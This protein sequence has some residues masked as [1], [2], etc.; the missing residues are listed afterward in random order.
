M[1]LLGELP[2]LAKFVFKTFI[3]TTKVKG[4]IM[5]GVVEVTER[6]GCT[7]INCA[8]NKEKKCK[9]NLETIKCAPPTEDIAT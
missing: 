6:K 3:G 9:N 5:K 4:F 7:L 1:R 2:L 8:Y